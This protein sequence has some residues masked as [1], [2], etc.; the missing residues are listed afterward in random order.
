VN[1]TTLRL[2]RFCYDFYTLRSPVILNAPLLTSNVTS[3]LKGNGVT[4]AEAFRGMGLLREA[5]AMVGPQ[6]TEALAFLDKLLADEGGLMKLLTLLTFL[7]LLTLLTLQN[8]LTLLNLMTSEP[9][10]RS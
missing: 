10:Q 7:T 6:H 1:G 9:Y 4:P 2:S 5:R 3:L 8:P